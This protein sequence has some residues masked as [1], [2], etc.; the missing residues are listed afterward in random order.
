ME[1]PGCPAAGS[2]R[3]TSIAQSNAH[4]GDAGRAGVDAYGPDACVYARAYATAELAN[5][6][7]CER[8]AGRRGYG[9]A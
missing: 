5:C 7:G 8:D 3:R 1:D 2:S 9:D 6:H 4:A